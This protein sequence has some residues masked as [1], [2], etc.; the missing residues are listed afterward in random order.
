VTLVENPVTVPPEP[1]QAPGRIGV[2]ASSDDFGCW[3]GNEDQLWQRVWKHHALVRYAITKQ[4]RTGSQI[5]FEIQKDPHYQGP[6]S[7]EDKSLIED[8]FLYPNP[9]EDD[10]SSILYQT[11]A[12]LKVTGKSAWEV[13][14]MEENGQRR[15]YDFYY[16]PGVV[17]P[18]VDQHGNF[19]DP[20]KAYEQSIGAGG[21]AYLAADEVIFFRLPDIIKGGL[22]GASDLQALDSDLSVDIFTSS[23]WKKFY[24]N[25]ATKKVAYIL[26]KG[27]G[28]E[29]YERTNERIKAE[30]QSLVRG[31][32]PAVVV[33]GETDIKD[34]DYSPKELGFLAEKEF[35]QKEILMASGAPLERELD[36]F[37]LDEVQPLLKVIEHRINWY[38]KAIWKIY[39]WQFKFRQFVPSDL[40]A[41]ARILQILQRQGAVTIN[42]SRGFVGL[43]PKEGG[44]RLLLIAPTGLIDVTTEQPIGK[45]A[46]ATLGKKPAVSPECL[47][48]DILHRPEM[49]RAIPRMLARM[50]SAAKPIG[51]RIEKE[52]RSLHSAGR[53][54]ENTFQAALDRIIP[55]DA[56]QKGIY[57]GMVDS[58]GEG[59]QSVAKEIKLAVRRIPDATASRI[60]HKA[61]KLSD[62]LVSRLKLGDKAG[63]IKIASYLAEGLL[64]GKD[65]DQLTEGVGE[66]FRNAIDWQSKEI[67][68]SEVPRAYTEGQLSAAKETGKSR[69]RIELGPNSCEWCRTHAPFIET[70]EEAEKYFA[71]HHPNVECSLVVLEKEE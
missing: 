40:K 49:R 11:L 27:L 61:T 10:I 4:A 6:A 44:D 68:N 26:Q 12:K 18:I 39:G 16:L 65:I 5:E 9:Q 17:R 64:A 29:E 67:A 58:W 36:Q 47:Q 63:R 20:A 57:T 28:P 41:T 23:W 22:H 32:Q 34:L 35:L 33:D 43:A 2:T 7:E 46:P 60:W 54:D 30:H 53:L 8:F 69:V 3:D 19:K 48:A 38:I 31:Q 55:A 25:N 51:G 71:D 1:R 24:K 45:E 42:E 62:D 52:M 21:Q 66:V 13:V 15:P 70:A 56:F 50:E 14:W 37:F 59:D